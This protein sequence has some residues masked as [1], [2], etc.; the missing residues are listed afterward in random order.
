MLISAMRR[1]VIAIVVLVAGFIGANTLRLLGQTP[2]DQKPFA[3]EVATVKANASGGRGVVISGTPS[4]FITR[5]TPL[6]RIIGYALKVRDDQMM[7]LPAWTHTE[8]FDITGKYSAGSRPSSAQVAQMVRGLLADR[9]K[10][11]T[12]TETREGATFA[13]VL[14][15]R[16]GRLGPN[17]TPHAFDCAAYLAKSREGV[18]EDGPKAWPPLCAPPISAPQRIWASVRPISALAS[19]LARQVGRPVVDQTGLTGTY[20]FNLKWSIPV[21]QAGPVTQNSASALPQPEEG[22]SLFTALD[23]QLGLTLKSTRGPVDV[24]V[25]DHVEK[26]TED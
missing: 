22:L 3:F 10:L 14:A 11:Q 21:Q 18:V 4:E 26:P 16:D 24:L 23:E 19:A 8:R 12:H 7:G 2:A 25:I 13:L 5:N 1:L 9:F 20:D 15:R 6:A 17:L